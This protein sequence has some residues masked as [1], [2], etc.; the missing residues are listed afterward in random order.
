MPAQFTPLALPPAPPRRDHFPR[1]GLLAALALVLLLSS[2]QEVV[3]HEIPARVTVHT[4]VQPEGGT[5]RLLVR[6]PLNAMR[7]FDFPVRGPGYLE[8]A[9]AEPL[10]YEAARLWIVDYVRLFEEGNL[11]RGERIAG[12][13]VSLPSDRSFDSFDTALEHIQ[14][15]P[16]LPEDTDIHWEQ[17]LLDVLVEYPIASDESR[18][19]IDSELAHLG[20]T[21]V[22][23]LRFQLPDNPE[24]LFQFTGVPGVVELDPSWYQAAF[25]FVQLGFFHILEGIDH[26]LFIFCLV[27][28]FRRIFPLIA[29]I[30][31]FTIA[32]SITLAA[33]A[34]G[35]APDALWFPPLIEALIALSIVYMAFENIVGG[36]TLRRRWLMAFGFGLVHGFGFSFLL[37][38]SLQFAGS[39]LVTSLF[40]FNLGVELGQIAVVLLAV[41]LLAL[42]FR[43]VV[44]ERMGVILLSALVAHTAWHWMADR[45]GDFREHPFEWPLLDAAFLASLMRGA[46]A[47]LILA[48]IVWIMYEVFEKLEG[49]KGGRASPPRSAPGAGG[50]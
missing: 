18:F 43:H 26:L 10:L 16:R 15:A 30:T 33:S 27:I 28:P 45:W 19:S 41:P 35:F 50:A 46:M 17:A 7:D 2:P 21:T 12:A 13:R 25:R 39:H 6:V 42:L 9:E 3:P 1:R 48:G 36:V 44:E 22:T 5:L 32:H 4:F 34:L 29:I 38:E 37:R 11:L 47:V 20:I 40:S 23:I 8:I 49:W 14:S 31:S 24:R